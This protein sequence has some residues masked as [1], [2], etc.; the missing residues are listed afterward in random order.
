MRSS[1][2]IIRGKVARNSPV[3]TSSSHQQLADRSSL[4]PQR[5]LIHPDVQT[6]HRS[7]CDHRLVDDH[8]QWSPRVYLQSP[9]GSANGIWAEK[10][11]CRRLDRRVRRPAPIE[12]KPLAGKWV[13]T[14]E[15]Y[16]VRED[17]FLLPLPSN[18]SKCM[19][20]SANR[21]GVCKTC[22]LRATRPAGAI[23]F[24]GSHQ[25]FL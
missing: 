9:R 21:R 5:L 6:T 23:R 2:R 19:I 4:T 16:G 14:S 17:S 20:C 25:A 24:S 8:L 12:S 10:P 18:D 3:A 22:R 7:G 11:S 1:L 15:P 13:D